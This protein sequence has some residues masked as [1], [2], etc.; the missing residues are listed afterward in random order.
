ME[1]GRRSHWTERTPGPG[2]LAGHCR[3]ERDGGHEPLDDRKWNGQE[4][5]I[6]RHRKERRISKINDNFFTTSLKAR[7]AG[8]PE[9][10]P[11]CRCKSEQC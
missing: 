9:V 3:L 10:C 11:S 4:E 5:G 6:R 1:A 2:S 8:L 7:A